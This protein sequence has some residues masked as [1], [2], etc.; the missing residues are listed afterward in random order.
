M[1][2]CK[3]FF[4]LMICQMYISSVAQA[5]TRN[6]SQNEAYMAVNRAF[7]TRDVDYYLIDRNNST[8]WE[9]FVDAEPMKGWQH[10][11]YI[12]HV[13]RTVNELD[14][15]TTTRFARQT[16]P[17]D[18]LIPLSEINRIGIRA[19]EKPI[20]SINTNSIVNT[21]A[22]QRTYA[23]ILSGGY[24]KNMNY[25]RYWND[26][27]FIYQTLIKK[28]FIPKNNI[29]VIMSDGTNPAADMRTTSPYSYVSS[30]LDL[31]NDGVSDIQYAAT[32]SNVQSVISSLNNTMQKDD[33]LFIF[34]IDHGGSV[35]GYDESFICLW[36]E[37]RIYDYELAN[38][39][40][41]L[42]AKGVNVN[43][44]LGQCNSGGFIDNLSQAGCVVAAACN[45]S[46]SSYACS[47]I[48]FDEFVYEWTSAVN[49]A[50]HLGASVISDSDNNGH[51]TMDEAF[52]YANSHDDCDET[53]Q[54]SSNPRSIG[55][56][57][58]FDNI[59]ASVDL[60]IKDNNAD[61]GKQPN[62]TTDKFW[63]SPS[64]WVRNQ[65]DN[66]Y[67][68]ENPYYAQDHLA[69]VVYVWVHNRGK[70]IYN[71]S[72]RWVHVYWAKAS[73]A[74]TTEAWKGRELY[75]NIVTGGHIYACP[76]NMDIAPGDSA[77][78]KTT[79]ALP[80]ILMEDTTETGGDKHHY[81]LLAKIMDTHI[82]DGYVP[83]VTYFN[84]KGD[85]NVAQKN[86]SIVPKT[87]LM[88]GINVFVRNISTSSKE[89]TLELKPL[90]TADEQIYSMA[91]IEMEL[92]PKIYDAWSR[93][94]F[95]SNSISHDPIA[96]PRKVKFTS[97]DSRLESISLNSS[98]FDRV[99]LKFDFSFIPV[100][101]QMYTL[102]LIQRNDSG[103][104]IGGETFVVESPGIAFDTTRVEP[105]QL[106]GTGIR[107]TT[108]IE[109]DFNAKWRNV[110][111]QVIGTDKTVI[112][113]PTPDNNVYSV[114]ALTEEGDL[115][116]GSI[117]LTPA[118]GI[119][120]ISVDNNYI[121][122]VFY[123][124]TESD[125]HYIIINSLSDV[126]M[127]SIYPIYIGDSDMQIDISSLQH[128]TY[129][130]SYSADGQSINSVKFNK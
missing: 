63:A 84:L 6:V 65:D 62:L 51:I 122:I 16:P 32:K 71:T 107:L 118:I 48:P 11:C 113:N 41:V 69:S 2:S 89:Y 117:A 15:I 81:C 9:F 40:S 57:L 91:E 80:N 50:N 127:Q 100:E 47:N 93:G 20:V 97:K 101:S 114:T 126:N 7:I 85:N 121:N 53:P 105:I 25:E 17:D 64:I 77:L 88:K 103:E 76:L 49:Q 34:V 10:E 108:D 74:L 18:N 39:L 27:S 13:P 24:N 72:N 104:I 3:F 130:V 60:Y 86:V 98:E 87:D 28:Y 90:T 115:T 8:Y 54:Y 128:G 56:D 111:G 14:P 42:L 61:T 37:D 21:S 43:A 67:E 5:T 35:N 82:D 26:C 58:A 124:E 129:L 66:I 120:S 33:H 44:V 92:T 116:T 19:T 30:P 1:K 75:N 45:G 125:N 79:W 46:E 106:P 95:H 12:V 112:V 94:G 73:T 119:K 99:T 29:S 96:A 36:G 109:G 23:I 110:S 38:M 22:S 102:D 55:E 78:V 4:L 83:G 123:K 31:D 68:H 59:A 70:E 52:D